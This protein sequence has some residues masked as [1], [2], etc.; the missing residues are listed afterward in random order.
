VREI[1][2][3][4]CTNQDSLR[5]FTFLALW[6]VSSKGFSERLRKKDLR[7]KNGVFTLKLAL[8]VGNTVGISQIIIQ[9]QKNYIQTIIILAQGERK[10]TERF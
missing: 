5:H 4:K 8:K 6:L 3:V 7:G 1:I 9:K 10:T 2:V